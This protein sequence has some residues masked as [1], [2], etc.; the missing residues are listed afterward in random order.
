MQVTVI[1]K[2]TTTENIEIP[3]HGEVVEYGFDPLPIV[4]PV[5]GISMAEKVVLPVEED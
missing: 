2:P 4:E 5:D 1:K 3:D